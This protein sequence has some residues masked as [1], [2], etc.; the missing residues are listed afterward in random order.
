MELQLSLTMD[1]IRQ[2]LCSGIVATSL[3]GCSTLPGNQSSTVAPV[4]AASFVVL[5][6]DGIPVARVIASATQCPEISFD[7]Q[8]VAMN[9][10]AKAETIPLRTT[11]SDPADSKPAVFPV[12]TCEK[13]IPPHTLVVKVAGRLLP[14]PKNELKR[15]VVIG[16]TGCRLKRSDNAYQACNDEAQYPFAKIAAEAADWKPDLVIHVGDFLY[17]ENACP[18]GNVECSGSTWGYGWDAWRDDFFNPA[19]S[20][21]QAAPWVMGARQS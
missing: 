10:R 16:D 11:R 14:L 6:V 12:I 19:R 3:I 7:G 13:N 18:D 15:V 9:L 1:T 4:D 20:L 17:R 21:L 2:A 5:G 8:S